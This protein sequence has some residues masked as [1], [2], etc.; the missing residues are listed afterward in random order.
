MSTVEVIVIDYEISKTGL[1]YISTCT[2]K[3]EGCSNLEMTTIYSNGMNLMFA[4]GAE[5]SKDS[6]SPW[7]GE[8][9]GIMDIFNSRSLHYHSELKTCIKS[10]L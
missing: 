5:M 6:Y 7:T 4:C 9:I 1:S 8:L 10:F 3:Q 2:F